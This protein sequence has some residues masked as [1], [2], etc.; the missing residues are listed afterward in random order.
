MT[1]KDKNTWGRGTQKS[2]EQV[3]DA[4]KVDRNV[5]NSFPASRAIGVGTSMEKRLKRKKGSSH[6]LWEKSDE[7]KLSRGGSPGVMFPKIPSHKAKG[8]LEGT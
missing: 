3:H 1:K 6:K 7:K 5:Q 2:G 8:G 4:Q